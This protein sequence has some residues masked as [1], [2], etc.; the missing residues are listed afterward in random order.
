V[1]GAV[2]SLLE[3]SVSGVMCCLPSLLQLTQ[4]TK[5]EAC[6][7]LEQQLSRSR[8]RVSWGGCSGHCVNVSHSAHVRPSLDGLKAGTMNKNGCKQPDGHTHF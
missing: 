3:G 8:S 7:S 6:Y 4:D 5:D 1:F 2:C